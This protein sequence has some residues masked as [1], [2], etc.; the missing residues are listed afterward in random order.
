MPG[1]I[2]VIVPTL[3]AGIVLLYNLGVSPAQL[4]RLYADWGP[5]PARIPEGAAKET[6]A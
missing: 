1:S 6:T 2:A 4:K 5:E 3:N